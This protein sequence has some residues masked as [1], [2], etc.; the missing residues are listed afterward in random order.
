LVSPNAKPTIKPIHFD[1]VVAIKELS[2]MPTGAKLSHDLN[3][4]VYLI[5]A[6]NKTI[7]PN[8]M[9]KLFLSEL[10]NPDDDYSYNF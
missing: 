3:K 6:S 10:S 7:C 8:P 4:Y 5:G 2:K 1:N 9:L